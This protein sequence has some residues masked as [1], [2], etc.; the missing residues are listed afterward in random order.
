[1]VAGIEMAG[2]PNSTGTLCDYQARM[3]KAKSPVNYTANA[4]C[5]GRSV[6][7]AAFSHNHARYRFSAGILASD[8]IV[9]CL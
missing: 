9:I 4:K 5:C 6:M 7:A 1:M 3:A 2:A 8:S